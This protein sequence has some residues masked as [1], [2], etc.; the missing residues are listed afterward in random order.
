[1]KVTGVLS[2]DD[3]SKDPR[4]QNKIPRY[5]LIEQRGDNIY[6]RDEEGVFHQ[7]VPSYHSRGLR[8]TTRGMYGEWII[9]EPWVEHEGR[10]KKDLKGEFVPISSEGNFWYFG[11]GKE[12]PPDL[13]WVIKG[14]QGY[15][16]NHPIS[17]IELFENWIT[18]LKPGIHGEPFDLEKT[19]LLPAE[20]WKTESKRDPHQNA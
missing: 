20:L 15:K 3:Y 19:P 6:H 9:A 17:Q 4:F 10:K 5:G 7:S 1:M 14:G 11:R 2:F 16:C 18:Q 13:H 8:L 12:L